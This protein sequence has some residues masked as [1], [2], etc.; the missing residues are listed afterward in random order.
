[1]L[2]GPLQLFDDR[3]L[4][5]ISKLGFVKKTPLAEYARP[6]KGGIIG[7][8]LKDDDRLVRALLTSGGA[9]STGAATASS[10]SSSSSAAAATASTAS[11]KK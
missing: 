8:G 2:Y 9:T 3:F 5:T 1:M 4:F 11:S 6:K 10:S 7:A